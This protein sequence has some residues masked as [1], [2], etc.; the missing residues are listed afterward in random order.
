MKLGTCVDPSSESINS[1]E[2]RVC[3]FEYP[4]TYYKVPVSC[5]LVQVPVSMLPLALHRLITYYSYG[6]YAPFF[7]F[8]LSCVRIYALCTAA[9][10]DRRQDRVHPG[11]LRSE[12]KPRC[13]DLKPLGTDSH[14]DWDQPLIIR[15]RKGTA[16]AYAVENS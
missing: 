10:T 11:A 7:F 12:F 16:L 4:R 6:G 14:G 5:F 15:E 3:F 8:L 9:E 1:V 2:G 13:G